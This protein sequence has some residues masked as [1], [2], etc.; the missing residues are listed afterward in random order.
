M[1]SRKSLILEKKPEISLVVGFFRFG[2]KN[3]FVDVLFF[4][5]HDAP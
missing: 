5:L 1:Q 3:C 2:K 4:C